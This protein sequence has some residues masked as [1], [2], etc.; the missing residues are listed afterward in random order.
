M[1][2]NILL[3][4]RNIVYYYIDKYFLFEYLNGNVRMYDTTNTREREVFQTHLKHFAKSDYKVDLD[5]Y[6]LYYLHFI[7]WL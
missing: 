7:K 6:L 5:T 2:N 3:R 1:V 4:K